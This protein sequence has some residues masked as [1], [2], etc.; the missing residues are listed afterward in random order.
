[1]MEQLL[2]KQVFVTH[3]CSY[4]QQIVQ[5]IENT[6]DQIGGSGLPELSSFPTSLSMSPSCGMIW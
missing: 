6:S 5:K 4:S 3:N 1:M 2:R